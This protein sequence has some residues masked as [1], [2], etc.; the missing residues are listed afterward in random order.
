[1]A[2]KNG[3][4]TYVFQPRFCGSAKE[5]GLILPVPAKLSAPPA[6]SNS[7][8]FNY[9]DSISQPTYTY[10]TVCSF[11]N[12][13]GGGGST[14]ASRAD[15]GITVVSTGTV[16][17]MDYAQIETGSTAALT[18]WLDGNGYPHDALATAAFDY[19]VAK[20]W[21]FVALVPQQNLWVI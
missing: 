21:Y 12:T 13:A 4:E 17:F 16:G 14:G 20:G 1:M 5:F 2:H 11:G 15:A 10:T 3:T 18:A 8:V 19:Y 9:L 7:G 6:L